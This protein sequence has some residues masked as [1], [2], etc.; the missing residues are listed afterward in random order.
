M[1]PFP[2]RFRAGF[3]LHFIGRISKS[4]EGQLLLMLSRLAFGRNPAHPEALV[5]NIRVAFGPV[6]VCTSSGEYLSRTPGS[7]ERTPGSFKMTPRKTETGI[8]LSFQHNK[9][10]NG[11]CKKPEK[12][13]LSVTYG[14]PGPTSVAPGGQDRRLRGAGLGPRRAPGVD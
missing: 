1:F 13:S 8:Y 5:H 9:R 3:R 12:R 4:A 6:F 7:F 14:S 10:S 11:N 2:A